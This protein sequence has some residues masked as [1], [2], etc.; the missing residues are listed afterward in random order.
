R[1]RA[2]RCS[3]TGAKRAGPRRWSAR[4]P[5]GGLWA[6]ASSTA[7]SSPA[8]GWRS[9]GAG[10]PR[11]VSC[12]SDRERRAAAAGAAGLRVDELEPGPGHAHDVVDLSAL[13]I[14]GAHRVDVD[15]HVALLVDPV[16]VPGLALE[17][18]GVL[19]AAAPAAAHRD[20]QPVGRIDALLLA[21]DLHHLDRLGRQRDGHVRLRGRSGVRLKRRLRVLHD[22]PPPL[23]GT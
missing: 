1:R 23:S 16:V 3:T 11:S 22:G 19:E 10:P 5:W 9:K 21:G 7:G 17:V 15:R 14:A 18:E 8:L 6:S 2:R 20:A 4:P 12:R 13:E